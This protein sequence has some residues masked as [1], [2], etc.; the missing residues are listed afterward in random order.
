[1]GNN[2]NKAI[3]I[4]GLPEAPI[5]GLVLENIKMDAKEGLNCKFANDLVLKNIELNITGNKPVFNINR[6][7]DVTIDNCKARKSKMD[8][9]VIDIKNSESIIVQNCKARGGTEIFFRAGNSRQIE[10]L[11]NLLGN[12][13]IIK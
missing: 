11:N 2:I 6:S 4:L 7:A 5:E 1:M 9:P 12:A 8:I 3:N 13:K 10:F